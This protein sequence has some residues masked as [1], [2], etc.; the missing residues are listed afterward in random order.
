MMLI[1]LQILVFCS[2]F[3]N[4]SVPDADQVAKNNKVSN[5]D[6]G[7]M[8]E[9]TLYAL[10]QVR[11]GHITPD[12]IEVSQRKTILHP[13][14]FRKQLKATKCRKQYQRWKSHRGDDDHSSVDNTIAG[15][16]SD[17]LISHEQCRSL[18]TAKMIYIA[19]Q[20]LEVQ[21]DTKNPIVITD[22]PTSS[23]NRNRCDGRGWITRD[24]FLPQM[25]RTTL[26]VRMSTGKSW[27]DSAQAGTTAMGELCCQTTSLDSYA[28]IW[29]YPDNC[30]LSVLRTEDI[31][32]VK[33]GSK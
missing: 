10:N 20:F 30:L 33:Q 2:E 9:N 18:A 26:E 7:A 3:I 22:V 4:T 27:S 8:T 15:I 6:C 21:N 32:M 23:T 19:D 17:L 13:E 25:Q 24:R 28:Y 1:R 12:E 31:K 11:Q 16:T 14:H 5:F 29:D